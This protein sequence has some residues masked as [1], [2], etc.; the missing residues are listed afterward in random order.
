LKDTIEVKDLSFESLLDVVKVKYGLS[1]RDPLLMQHWTGPLV[2]DTK[3][4]LKCKRKVFMYTIDDSDQDLRSGLENTLLT[5]GSSSET[6][7]RRA[8]AGGHGKQKV[9]SVLPGSVPYTEN[10]VLPTLLPEQIT[11]IGKEK[12]PGEKNI[13][14]LCF[15]N[16]SI[17]SDEFTISHKSLMTLPEVMI[18]TEPFDEGTFRKVNLLTVLKTGKKFVIKQ[19]KESI[20]KYLKDTC[21]LT[22]RELVFKAVKTITVADQ[23]LS[24]FLSECVLTPSGRDVS[25]V[26]TNVLEAYSSADMSKDR[27]IFTDPEIA[28]TAGTNK[29]EWVFTAGNMGPQAIRKFLDKH[30]CNE[31]C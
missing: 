21:S 3:S 6:V 24:K 16:Y 9:R 30:I 4:L 26:K 5:R 17:E 13:P 12:C 11:I 2:N 27:P 7:K 31:Y 10:K 23:M 22:S 19:V 29:G 14:F 15:K 8:A 18:D 28:S 1:T 20:E 25:F